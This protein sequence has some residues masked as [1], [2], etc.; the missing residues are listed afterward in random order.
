MYAC[1]ST[2][3]GIS[4]YCSRLYRT[5]EAYIIY[6][7]A[8]PSVNLHLPHI[9]KLSSS[10]QSDAYTRKTGQQAE[11]SSGEGYSD[12][13]LLHGGSPQWACTKPPKMRLISG[14]RLLRVCSQQLTDTKARR[15]QRL[16]LLRSLARTL[17]CPYPMLLSPRSSPRP[18]SSPK[19]RLSR[20]V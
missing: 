6:V 16:R 19:P 18:L 5:A 7:I 1:S 15:E 4:P 10:S 3:F 11:P 17:R 20:E 14:L 9:I 2:A 12:G 13:G 8:F